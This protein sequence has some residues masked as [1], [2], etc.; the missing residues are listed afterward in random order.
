MCH[1]R[2]IWNVGGIPQCC[3]V[4][5]KFAVFILH[6]FTLRPQKSLPR[7]LYKGFKNLFLQ[8]SLYNF[9]ITLVLPGELPPLCCV[10]CSA[11]EPWSAELHPIISVVTALVVSNGQGYL[12]SG[13]LP[14]LCLSENGA[15]L[16]VLSF[17]QYK[18]VIAHSTLF[19]TFLST[20]EN[21]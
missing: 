9:L 16:L 19:P 2:P 12:T 8:L 14:W 15:V 20:Y 21:G 18:V 11:G 3:S 6:D 4:P 5:K 17:S 1:S 7:T 13:C 10:L